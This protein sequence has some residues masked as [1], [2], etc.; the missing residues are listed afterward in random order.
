[1][2]VEPGFGGQ[3]FIVGA[4]AKIAQVRTEP[5]LDGDRLEVQVDGGV[6]EATAATVGRLGVDVMVVGSAL[7]RRDR[8]MAAEVGLVR[9]AAD[10]G[11]GR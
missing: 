11:R 1:M 6:N 2:T 10:A 8:P 5:G 9:A 3:S 7:F 4:A